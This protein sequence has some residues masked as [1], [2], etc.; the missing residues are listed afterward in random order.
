MRL[1]GALASI[2]G[3]VPRDH[4]S[5]DFT[6]TEANHFGF[7]NSCAIQR[8]SLR[9]ADWRIKR[10]LRVYWHISLCLRTKGFWTVAQTARS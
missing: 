2:F 6:I 4:E 9:C 1:N 5:V 7:S 8:F 10:R 3:L